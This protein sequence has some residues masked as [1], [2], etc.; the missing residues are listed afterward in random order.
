MRDNLNII[1]FTYFS[2]FALTFLAFCLHTSPRG[3]IL[4]IKAVLLFN[5]RYLAKFKIS[6]DICSGDLSEDRSLVPT[7]SI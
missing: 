1:Y 4:E 5:F 3:A 7:C 6:H 2:K